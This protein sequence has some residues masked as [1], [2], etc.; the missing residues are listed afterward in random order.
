MFNFLKLSLNKIFFHKYAKYFTPQS[1]EYKADIAVA[2]I[3][4]SDIADIAKADIA[5]STKLI[6]L[7]FNS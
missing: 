4:K 3:A 1:T 2:D 6:Y 5:L 7:Y